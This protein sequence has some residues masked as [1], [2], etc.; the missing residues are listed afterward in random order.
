ML[1]F[2]IIKSEYVVLHVQHNREQDRTLS[3]VSLCDKTT[4]LDN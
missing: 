4:R 3:A 1:K 2:I